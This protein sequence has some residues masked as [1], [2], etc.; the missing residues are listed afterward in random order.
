MDLTHSLTYHIT[1][2]GNLLRQVTAQRIRNE[3]INL[4]PEESVL[5]NQLWDR[6]KQTIAELRDWTVKEKSTLTRQ[7][8]GLAKKN[9]IKRVTSPTDRRSTHIHLTSKGKSL[10]KTFKKTNVP[11]LDNDYI[12][13]SSKQI[14]E[15]IHLLTNIREQALEELQKG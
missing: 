7:L 2:T 3:G 13:L 14:E 8:D 15:Y 5:M 4:T 9:L 11:S 10:Q 6:D 1:K 12:H